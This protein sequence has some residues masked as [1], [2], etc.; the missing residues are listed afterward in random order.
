MATVTRRMS[1][2]PQRVYEVLADP[3]CYQHWVVGASEVVESD[4]GWPA[5]GTAFE[6]RV[7]V[8]PLRV[9]DHTR[10]V[11][12]DPPRMIKLA[13]KARPLGTATV[14]ME[15]EPDGSGC[16]VRMTEGPRDRFTAALFNKF[17][18]PVIRL[19]NIEA[20]RRLAKLAEQN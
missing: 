1:V 15:M 2:P 9:A 8:W 11:D 12:S 19:R 5:I 16:I 14:V 10:V 20:L 13:A 17:S 4:P 18:E 6:H 7:G 3:E